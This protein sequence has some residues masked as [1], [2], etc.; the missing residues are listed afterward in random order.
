VTQG[1]DGAWPLLAAILLLAG[2]RVVWHWRAVWTHRH[3]SS[4]QLGVFLLLVGIQ[5]VIVYAVSRCGPLSVLTLRY[6]LLGVF[7]PT[8]LALLAWTVE[9]RA[10]LR[11]LIG[12]SFVGLAVLNAWPHAQLWHEQLTRPSIS[13]RAQ[14]G[15]ALES[16]GIHFARSDYWTAYYVAFM[17]RERVVVGADTL[18]RVD[19]YERLLARHEREVVHVTTDRCDD[20]PAIVPGYYLCPMVAP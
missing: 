8:G 18:S 9:R 4:V 5:S 20:T 10:A 13:N 1:I 3:A 11:H 12:A 15:A 19:V 14:L 16:R 6:A 7:L 2:L 17:T